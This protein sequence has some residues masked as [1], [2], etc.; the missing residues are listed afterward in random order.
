[1]H[2]MILD[3]ET[4]PVNTCNIQ[5]IDL[6]WAHVDVSASPGKIESIC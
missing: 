3:L 4:H 2:L 1:M 5:P 6:E